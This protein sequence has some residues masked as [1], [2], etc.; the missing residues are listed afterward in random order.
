[1][2]ANKS[3]VMIF[4]RRESTECS[5]R[6]DGE[7]LEDVWKFMYLGS[8]LNKEGNI[9]DK[10]CE[11]VQQG[12]RVTGSLKGVLRNREVSMEVKR[13]LHDKCCGPCADIWE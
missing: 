7:S 4:E 5:V 12:R 13:L 8:V 11:W 6:L 10:V 9:E 3:K 2:N 1:M